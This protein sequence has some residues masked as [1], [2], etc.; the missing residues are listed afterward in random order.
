MKQTFRDPFAC[1]MPMLSREVL[2][3][4]ETLGETTTTTLSREVLDLALGLMLDELHP[5]MYLI[6]L[7]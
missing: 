2:D 5:R 1:P 6:I 3:L 7:F 4:G